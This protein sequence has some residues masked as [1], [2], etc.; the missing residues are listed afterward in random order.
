MKSK[1]DSKKTIYLIIALLVILTAYYVLTKPADNQKPASPEIQST[2]S[3]NTAGTA[4][5]TE[6]N[7][8]TDTTQPQADTKT[9]PSAKPTASPSD[10]A[11]MDETDIDPS[12]TG[13]TT[14]DNGNVK[15]N[16]D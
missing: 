13:P 8:A 14:T 5:G 1:M 4:A 16:P 2:G 6:S 10:A 12:Y 11:S 9:N 7:A 3:E 15:V